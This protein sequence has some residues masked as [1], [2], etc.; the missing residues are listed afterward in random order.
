[1]YNFVTLFIKN[2]QK[3]MRK[4]FLYLSIKTVMTIAM[5]MACHAVWGKIVT[6]CIKPTDLGSFSAYTSWENKSFTS[7]AIYQGNSTGTEYIQFR[8]TN[9]NTGIIT[10]TS[11]GKAQ[12]I[13]VVWH[14]NTAAGRILHIYGKN[15]AYSS[16]A[17]LFGTKK[18]TELGTIVKGT[19]TELTI[20]GDYTF[21]GISTT[22]GTAYLSEICIQWEDSP[23]DNTSESSITFPQGSYIVTLG[24]SFNAPKATLGGKQ[25]D[26]T[27]SSSDETVATV[28][29]STG[30]VTLLTAGETTITAHYDG[31]GEHEAS[32]ASYTLVVMESTESFVWDV[33]KQGY[34]EN[35]ILRTITDENDPITITFEN[36]GGNNQSPSY[37]KE[38]N[39]AQFYNQNIVS[40]YAREGY[41]IN[42]ITFHYTTDTRNSFSANVG[43]YTVK[44]NSNLGEWKGVSPYVVITNKSG[45]A[46]KFTSIDVSYIPLKETAETVTI[47]SA[48]VATFCPNQTVVVGNG[49]MATIVTGVDKDAVL[50][51]KDIPVIPANTGVLLTGKAGT[52]KLY[53]CAG[54][55]ATP[56]A[57]NY[58]VGVT[59]DTPAIVDT[60]VLQNNNHIVSFYI[61]KEAGITTVRAGKAYL[62]LPQ[63]SENE[64]EE[65]AGAPFRG[66]ALFFSI[67]D[68][69]ATAIEVTPSP[70]KESSESIYTASGI[71][72]PTLQRG[73]N[74][75]RL[76]NGKT[77]KKWVP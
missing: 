32:T 73:I 15:T 53:T 46:A 49:T 48:G 77:V 64:S 40:L 56:P 4:R 62:T 72:V 58:L 5:I 21:I 51:T 63:T 26:V 69:H 8:E 22:G 25:V 18:G 23:D 75:V 14:S 67:E 11:G 7:N 42:G 9:K 74:I 17:D 66:T 76:A 37:R 2:F 44:N 55:T 35:T 30:A 50:I 16:V 31:S 20:T 45:S 27:Y 52:Y 36:G 47:S 68:A 28:N 70:T 3:E 71:K 60:Y 54:L 19:S 6:D 13:K 33:R 34:T 38:D 61:V 1:M 29:E 65:T 39:I 41:A 10:T 12:K 43:T 57:V 59:V 24:E